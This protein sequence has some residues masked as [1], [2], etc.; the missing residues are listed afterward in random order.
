MIKLGQHFLKMIKFSQNENP[1]T[2]ELELVESF[3]ALDLP[4][5]ANGRVEPVV[6]KQESV[7]DIDKRMD[8]AIHA[9]LDAKPP[10]VIK[11]ELECVDIEKWSRVLSRL[12]QRKSVKVDANITAMG[13]LA[14][15]PVVIEE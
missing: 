10:K 4:R 15:F 5:D 2:Q 1:M 9:V 8:C 7:G 6:V 3:D 14:M 13:L 11:E 12:Y